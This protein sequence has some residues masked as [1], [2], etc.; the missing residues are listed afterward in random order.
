LIKKKDSENMGELKSAIENLSS[1]MVTANTQNQKFLETLVEKS[2][3]PVK[4][5]AADAANNLND[6][7][8]EIS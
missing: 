3:L 7:D 6:S 2:S 1:L 4:K 8:Y 5:K